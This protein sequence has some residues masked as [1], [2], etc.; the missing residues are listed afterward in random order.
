MLVRSVLLL[1]AAAVAAAVVFLT[2]ASPVLAQGYPDKPIRLVIPFPAGGGA[3]ATVRGLVETMG[4]KLGQKFIIDP[5][6]GGGGVISIQHVMAQ[7]PDGYTLVNLTNSGAV[8]SA[9]PNPPFDIRK[10]LAGVAPINWTPLYVAVNTAKVPST[11]LKQLVEYAR[12]HP[13]TL[14]FGSYGVGSL[15]HL[16][17]EFLGQQ[18]GI[19]VT[20]VPYNGEA[21]NAA[22]LVRGDSDAAIGSLVSL[23]PQVATGKI[24]LVST[25]TA[26][27]SPF[28]PDVPGMGESGIPDFDISTYSLLAAPAGTPREILQKVNEALN[29]SLKEKSLAEY[30]AKLGAIPAGGTLEFTNDFLRKEVALYAKIITEGKLDLN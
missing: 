4:P 6:P 2:H 5:R 24:R 3:D 18:T 14:N 28:A 9:M 27:R 22:A 20:H 10:D 15:A 13:G 19:K 8:R 25:T 29:A 26:K 11:T 7:P 16:M 21:A 30:F 23:Q 17:I 12:A 1:P